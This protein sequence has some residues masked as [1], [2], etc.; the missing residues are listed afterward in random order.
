MSEGPRVWAPSEFLVH[1]MAAQIARWYTDRSCPGAHGPLAYAP[2]PAAVG[3]YRESAG[4]I[5]ATMEEAE[6]T[7]DEHHDHADGVHQGSG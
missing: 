6:V 2:A 1:S 7:G 4:G 5:H 3:I